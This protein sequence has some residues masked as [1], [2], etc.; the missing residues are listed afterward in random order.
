MDKAVLALLIGVGCALIFGIP[1]TRRSAR[2][3]KIYGGAAAQALHYIAASAFVGI[4]PV[5]LAS[6]ILRTGLTFPL[7]VSF[8]AVS[9]AS[10]FGFALFEHPTRPQTSAEDRGWT[11][12]DAEKSGL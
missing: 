3:E 5:V 2:K 9:F 10:L 6:L 7:A 11:K 8:L 12:D 4:L 1:I